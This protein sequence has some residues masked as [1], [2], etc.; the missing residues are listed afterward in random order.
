MAM[1]T[2]L[3]K[4]LIGRAFICENGRIKLFGKMDWTF[5]P[6]K[7]LAVAFQ[8]IAE[9]F[10]KDFLFELGYEAGHD[11]AIEM[12]RY[13]K[14]A[15]KGG[16]TTQ[17]AII[18]ILEFIGF[19]KFEIVVNR[20]EGEKHHFVLQ[21]KDNPVTEYSLKLYG[22]KSMI[23]NWFMGVYSAHAEMELGL[24]NPRFKEIKCV[25]NGA[26]FCIWETKSKP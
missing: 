5:I 1:A 4:L 21:V 23:C 20:I 15:P 16:W 10:G 19:G 6:S 11:A 22:Q 8:D 3:K 26:P 25:R 2:I 18:E 13:M 17:R 12:I 24:K 9:T 14:L 7:S